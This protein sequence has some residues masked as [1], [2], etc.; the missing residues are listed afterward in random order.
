MIAKVKINHRD[1]VEIMYFVFKVISS[2]NAK[3]VEKIRT[4][5][6]ENRPIEK[7]VSF[8]R[9][10]RIRSFFAILNVSRMID[11]FF[12]QLILFDF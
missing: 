9:N 12:P 7:I 11:I 4:E 2:I 1:T 5:A 6:K 3:S 10:S 8:V